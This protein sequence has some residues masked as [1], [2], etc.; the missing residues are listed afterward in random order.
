[1]RLSRAALPYTLRE[2]KGAEAG[3]TLSYR[4]RLVIWEALPGATEEHD[5]AMLT[6]LVPFKVRIDISIAFALGLTP[7]PSFSD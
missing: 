7:P 3:S 6:T 4:S 5:G 1:M 2:V